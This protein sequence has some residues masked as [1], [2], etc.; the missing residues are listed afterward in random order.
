[1][2]VPEG[3]ICVRDPS[4]RIFCSEKCLNR[5]NM[6]EEP[7]V[8]P[9]DCPGVFEEARQKD[10]RRRLVVSIQHGKDGGGTIG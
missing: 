8:P 1:M 5:F 3:D 2:D 6:E 4:G 7:L 9:P 10:A